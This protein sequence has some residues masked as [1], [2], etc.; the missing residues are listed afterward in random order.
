MMIDIHAH[1]LPGVDD[2]AKSVEDSIRMLKQAVDAGVNTICATPHVLNRIT[3][4]LDQAI[5][6]SFHLL[7]SRIE[8]SR[9]DLRLMLGSE[10][11]LRP[12]LLTLRGH[13]F[14]SLN[15]TGR[16]VLMELPLGELPVGTDRL[17][18]GLW[19]ED[20]TPII[21]H[22]E[23]SLT[24]TGHL[25][26]IES[27]VRQGALM[28]LNAGS[29]LGHFGRLCRKMAERL[30]D[31]GLVH[32]IASD[33]HDTESRSFYV[34]AQAYRKVLRLLDRDQAQRLFL[35]NPENILSGRSVWGMQEI[36]QA[37]G[38]SVGW[39]DYPSHAS[40]GCQKLT[41]GGNR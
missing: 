8:E 39:R 14:F 19:L 26:E 29:L 28:Q 27:L 37:N 40:V 7:K 38:K 12:D 31:L 9:L 33:A 3:P 16:Y 36:D 23:R 30:L 1:I 24:K 6:Q 4:Q 11:Y 20:I 34:L 18:Y 32:V 22:P 2:G 13:N 10:I 41:I 15:Q 25:R 5:N 35:H 17:V 21:A